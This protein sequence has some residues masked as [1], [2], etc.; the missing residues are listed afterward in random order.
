MILIYLSCINLT[1]SLKSLTEILIRVDLFSLQKD[2]PSSL[3]HMFH[4]VLGSNTV[5]GSLD[6][7]FNLRP[8]AFNLVC[9]TKLT[10]AMVECFVRHFVITYAPIHVHIGQKGIVVHNARCSNVS[11][12]DWL[13]SSYR[14]VI[15]NEKSELGDII[16]LNKSEDPNLCEDTL[17]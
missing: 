11:Q 17:L 13:Q 16:G 12:N 7:T 14:S 15:N 2:A 4:Q 1:I 8:Q 3:L 9:R 10:L 6:D 5:V